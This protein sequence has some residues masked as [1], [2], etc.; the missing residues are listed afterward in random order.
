LK[1]SLLFLSVA[2]AFLRLPA[3]AQIVLDDFSTGAQPREGAAL[4]GSSWFG[5]VT[6]KLTTITVAG[7][8]HDDNGWG[9]LNL[10]P[11]FDATGLQIT[12]IGQRD[13][14]NTAGSFNIQFF[15]TSLGAQA[16]SIP[17]TAFAVGNLTTVT[18]SFGTWVSADPTQLNGWTIGGGST[19]TNGADFRMTFDQL[20]LTT[21]AIPEPGAVAALAGIFALGFALW[22]RRSGETA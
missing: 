2:L 10:L 1:K 9:V 19:V 17:S 14:G 8:A 18:I 5:Q 3:E 13:A 12:I 15:D 11:V 4:E 21:S 7:T 22:R 6:Q 16:F 20:A